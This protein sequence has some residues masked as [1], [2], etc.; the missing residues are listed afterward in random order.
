[1]FCEKFEGCEKQLGYREHCFV[2]QIWNTYCAWCFDQD[3]FKY[4]IQKLFSETSEFLNDIKKC[5]NFDDYVDFWEY[6][7]EYRLKDF[8]SG[9]Y[10]GIYLKDCDDYYKYLDFIKN[11]E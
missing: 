9:T 3:N 1:M 7:Y 6:D 4:S 8:S 2:C 5:Y 11:N 10:G